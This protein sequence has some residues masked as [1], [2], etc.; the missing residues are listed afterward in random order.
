MTNCHESRRRAYRKNNEEEQS[1]SVQFRA[2]QFLEFSGSLSK[3]NN[4]VRSERSQS[5]FISFEWSLSRKSSVSQPTR[6]Q[7]E[8]EK[9]SLFSSKSQRLKYCRTFK[10]WAC[11]RFVSA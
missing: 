1:T 10:V 3:Q 2:V 6:V 9:V 8:L 4:P 11:R 5:E 7:K